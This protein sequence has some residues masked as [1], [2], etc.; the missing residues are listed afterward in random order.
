ME[1]LKKAAKY[2]TPFEIALWVCSVVL[3]GV[4]FGIFDGENRL[5]LAH[6][7]SARLLSSSRRK[8]TR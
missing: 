8:A 1:K 4:S 7:W 5:A 6:R 3:I 2:F